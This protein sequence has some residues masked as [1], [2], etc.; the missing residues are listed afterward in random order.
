MCL[1]TSRGRPL[2][3]DWQWQERAACR[4]MDS[5]DF[6]SPWGERGRARLDREE[7]ARRVCGRCEVADRCAAMAAELGEEYGI[8]GGMPGRERQRLGTDTPRPADRRDSATA[9]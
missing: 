9:S 1:P 7:R 8:W 2:L 6:F 3:S 5:S 4:G